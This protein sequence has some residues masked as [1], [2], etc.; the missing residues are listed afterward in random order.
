MSRLRFISFSLSPLSGLVS[1]QCSPHCIRFCVR[2]LGMTA[3]LSWGPPAPQPPEVFAGSGL[4]DAGAV[5]LLK[6]QLLRERLSGAETAV[7]LTASLGPLGWP[8]KPGRVALLRPAGSSC[9][10]RWRTCRGCDRPYA[11][12]ELHH[13]QPWHQDGTTALDQGIPLC[14][15]HHRNDPQHRLPPHHDQP[16]KRLE[17]PQIPIAK[18]RASK[19]WGRVNRDAIGTSRK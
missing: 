1:T 10:P 14:A 15:G 7:S 11:W 18:L 6:V 3:T 5:D 2:L 17:T 13:Q 12:S 19:T 9:L 4:L 8:V 16:S